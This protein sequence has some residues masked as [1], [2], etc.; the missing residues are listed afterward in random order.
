MSRKIRIGILYDPNHPHVINWANALIRQGADVI[1]F[2]LQKNTT[3]NLPSVFIPPKLKTPKGFLYPSYLFAKKEL[4]KKLKQYKIDVLHPIHLTPFATWGRLTNFRPIIP[5]AIGLDVLNYLLP[6]TIENAFWNKKKNTPSLLK[7]LKNKLLFSYYRKQILKNIRTA[8]YVVADGKF[9][10]DIMQKL[11]PEQKYQTVHWGLRPEL[12]RKNKELRRRIQE[13]YGVDFSKK[14]ILSPR[15]LA[16]V[17]NPETILLAAKKLLPKLSSDFQFLVLSNGYTVS[18]DIL[19][20]LRNLKK[21]HPNFIVF[22]QRISPEEIAQLWLNTR[23]FI[24]VPLEDGLP[25]S[26]Y[27]AMFSG[28]IPVLA[29]LPSY[30]ELL[31]PEHRNFQVIQ[32]SPDELTEKIWKAITFSQNTNFLQ[33]QRKHAEYHGN[34]YRNASRFIELC[35]Q[36]KV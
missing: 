5:M 23:V 25:V 20:L 36:Y 13:K 2:S 27:E 32:N 19:P 9:L 7:S 12:Y 8:D 26:L 18:E 17:Y 30:E 16:P 3:N 10:I 22:S 29:S 11:V 14:F 31:L 4:Q 28:A 33:K 15:G 34:I 21:R 35:K 1:V 24:S 6:G